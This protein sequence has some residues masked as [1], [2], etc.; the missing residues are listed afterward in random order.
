MPK[1]RTVPPDSRPAPDVTLRESTETRSPVHMTR[2]AADALYRA[3]CECCH[4]HDRVARILAR[5]SD[6]DEL[7]SAQELCAQSHASLVQQAKSYEKTAGGIRPDGADEQWW[8]LANALWLASREYVRRN[9]C[10]NAASREFKQHDRERLGALH[11]EYELEA[12]ALLA[13]KQAAD[14]YRQSRPDAL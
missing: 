3:A 2:D 7:A 5:S 9:S 8:H 4:Q 11:A 12:S 10:G 1:S 14:A 6:D 13:L